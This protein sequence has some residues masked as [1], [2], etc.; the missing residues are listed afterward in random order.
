M[1]KNNIYHEGISPVQDRKYKKGRK[2]M[3][4][5]HKHLINLTASAVCLALCIV[6]PFFT[7]NI[8]EIGGMLCPMH[9]PVL[10]CG[11]L[12]GPWYAMG[13]GLIAP[14]LR[15]LMFGMPPIFPTGV[16]MCM[17]LAVYGVVA[18]LL[19][20]ML[21]KKPVNIYIS[22]VLAMLLGRV[23]W[24]IAMMA[25]MGIAG[26]GFTWAA[27]ISGALLNAIPGIVLHIVLIP[28]VVMGVKRTKIMQE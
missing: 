5:L 13:I 28:L 7:G 23:A 18:G 9:I 11:F 27:F 2:I 8:P 6:L 22:L 26:D 20:K 17:E 19:Y 1:E 16:A 3:N 15:Y 10:L 21:P 25:I 14:L 12:C 4:K 24:G